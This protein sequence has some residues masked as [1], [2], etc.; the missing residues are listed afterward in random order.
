MAAF[1]KIVSGDDLILKNK[2]GVFSKNEIEIQLKEGHLTIGELGSI[3]GFKEYQ[4]IHVLKSL[5]ITYRNDLNDTRIIDASIDGPLHQVLIGTLLGDAYMTSNSYSLGHGVSQY[6]YCYHIAERLHQFIASFG[7]FNTKAKTKKSFNFWTYRHDVFKSYL[8]RFYSHGMNKKYF[9]IESIYDL[10]PE[11]L[12]Y[13]YMDDGKFNKHGAY[14]CV[15]AISVKEGKVF[16]DLLKNKFSLHSNLQCYDAKNNNYAIYIQARS[17]THFY[18]LIGPYIVPSMKYKIV[19]SKFPVIPF[20][21]ELIVSRHL[22]LCEKAKR[23]IRYFGDKDVQKEILEKNRF[24]NIKIE[25]I[26]R[27]KDLIKNDKIISKVIKRDISKERLIKLF[28]E[29]LSDQQVADK[30]G[31]GRNRIASLQRSFGITRKNTRMTLDKQEQ[32]KELFY[33]PCMTVQK[34]M[35]K[36]HISFYKV[37]EWVEKDQFENKKV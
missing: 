37:K 29:G 35:K 19:G 26:N 36:L 2:Y 3:Y 20:T 4:I 16:T 22:Q 21:K 32:L 33:E 9:T 28:G 14:L 27:I 23:Y 24:P 11:G 30:F 34:A 12:A 17:H 31:F 10:E 13:W 15:G 1:E 18:N 6:D 5:G 25:Y 7:D 8:T